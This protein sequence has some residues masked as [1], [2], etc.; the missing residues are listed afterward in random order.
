[1]WLCV[2]CQGARLHGALIMIVLRIAVFILIYLTLMWPHIIDRT[3]S[4]G[5]FKTVAVLYGVLAFAAS[6]II[7]P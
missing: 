4:G 2:Q 1:M 7:V 3:M 5:F 6:L